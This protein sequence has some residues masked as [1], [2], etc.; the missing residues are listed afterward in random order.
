MA[1]RGNFTALM[2]EYE[3]L[4]IPEQWQRFG[5]F[6]SEM[7][8]P[9]NASSTLHDAAVA[10]RDEMRGFFNDPAPLPFA[11]GYGDPGGGGVLL[12][13]WRRGLEAKRSER[14]SEGRGVRASVK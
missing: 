13:A 7:K 4:R 10:W 9:T 1:A 3:E 5:R 8:D 2:H 6:G 14:W 11:F 12:M